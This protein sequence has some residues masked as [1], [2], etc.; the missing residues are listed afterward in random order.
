MDKKKLEQKVDRIKGAHR[1]LLQNLVTGDPIN[2][3]A[4]MR[5]RRSLGE[6]G[7]SAGGFKAGARRCVTPDGDAKVKDGDRRGRLRRA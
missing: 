7:A 2:I 6:A 1:V 4:R 5:L 3:T